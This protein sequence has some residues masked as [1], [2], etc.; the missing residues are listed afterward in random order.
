MKKKCLL[1][2]LC[3]STIMMLTGCGKTFICDACEEEKR[4]K[5]H[6]SEVLGETIVLCDDCYNELKSIVSEIEGE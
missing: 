4:G 2:V 6:K 1:I 3:F 5:Q